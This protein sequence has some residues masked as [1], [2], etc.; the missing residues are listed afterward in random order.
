MSFNFLAAVT[1]YSTVNPSKLGVL[2]VV[3]VVVMKCISFTG[4]ARKVIRVFSVTSYRNYRVILTF[5]SVMVVVPSKEFFHFIQVVELIGW[6]KIVHNIIPDWFRI[7]RIC[8]GLASA[9]FPLFT[10]V[11]ICVFK[12]F[13]NVVRDLS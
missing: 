6:H 11:V 1:P 13:L 5:S 8:K 2:F 7:Y 3:R 4:L 10:I 9:G 12:S